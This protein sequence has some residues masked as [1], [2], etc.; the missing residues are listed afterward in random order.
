MK[1]HLEDGFIRFA[2]GA[3]KGAMRWILFWR[4][5]LPERPWLLNANGRLTALKF[6][7]SSPF[8]S[9]IRKEK[10]GSFA[11]MWINPS[12]AARLISLLNSSDSPI[13][14]KGSRGRESHH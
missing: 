4:E 9:A 8:E 7:L 6:S 3:I 11:P 10:I 12:G 1:S 5:A 13:F 14:P 2:T